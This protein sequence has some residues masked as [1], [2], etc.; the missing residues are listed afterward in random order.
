MKKFEQTSYILLAFG[1]ALTGL[2][3]IYMRDVFQAQDPFALGRPPLQGLSMK[4]HLACAV[5]FVF[6]FGWIAFSHAW[7]RFN[8][9]RPSGRKSGILNVWVIA[10]CILSGYGLQLLGSQSISFWVGWGHVL[11]GVAVIVLF[12]IHRMIVHK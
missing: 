8:S 5:F 2:V 7:L 3:Y 12:Y 11:L 9:G 6:I 10:A 4:L 1:L